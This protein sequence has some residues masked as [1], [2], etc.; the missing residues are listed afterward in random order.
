M[1]ADR[2][3][4]SNTIAEFL[5]EAC[6]KTASHIRKQAQDDCLISAA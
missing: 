3:I 1:T 5:P 2:R 6:D 4:G